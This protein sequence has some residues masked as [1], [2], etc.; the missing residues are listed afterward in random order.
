MAFKATVMHGTK[1]GER[2]GAL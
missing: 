2:R 1:G